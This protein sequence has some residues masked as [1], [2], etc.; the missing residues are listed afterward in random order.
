M[1]LQ[2]PVKL[3]YVAVRRAKKYKLTILKKHALDKIHALDASSYSYKVRECCMK[4]LSHNVSIQNVEQCIR[5]V[6]DLVGKDIDKLPKKSTLANMAV[7]ARSLAHLQI[8]EE[9]PF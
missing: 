7:E 2:T 6:L 9:L 5:A 3:S 1:I 4:L 8:A